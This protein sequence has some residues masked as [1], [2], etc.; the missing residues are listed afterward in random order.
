MKT[1]LREQDVRTPGVTVTSVT[2]KVAIIAMYI[3]QSFLWDTD[4]PLFV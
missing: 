1:Q 2:V 3:Y 4:D